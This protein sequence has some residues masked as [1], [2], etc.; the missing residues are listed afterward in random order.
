MLG[1]HLTHKISSWTV[2]HLNQAPRDCPRGRSGSGGDSLSVKGWMSRESKATAR[3]L[4]IR[5]Q[6]DAAYS[7]IRKARGATSPHRSNS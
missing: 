1:W 4:G 2:V 5:A 3:L 7:R 6:L